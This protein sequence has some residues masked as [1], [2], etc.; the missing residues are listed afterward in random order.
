MRMKTL[1]DN[2]YGIVLFR[3]GTSK[4][5]KT[6]GLIFFAILVFIILAQACYWLFA[7]SV[8][9]IIWGMPF[10]MF[11]VVILIL[12]EFAALAALYLGDQKNKSDEGGA[13]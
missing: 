10:G 9:P 8:T 1:R 11:A 5:E 3:P 2:D 4:A 12:M 6:R 13:Q 7:N